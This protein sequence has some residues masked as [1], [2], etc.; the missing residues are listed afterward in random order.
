[1]RLRGTFTKK[2]NELGSPLRKEE[3]IGTTLASQ[4]VSQPAPPV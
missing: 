1:M 4:P 2:R 3:L